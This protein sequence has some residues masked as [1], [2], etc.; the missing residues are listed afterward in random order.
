M[1]SVIEQE[2]KSLGRGLLMVGHG[3]RERC[4]R[5]KKE[6]GGGEKGEEEEG[7]EGR[8]DEGGRQTVISGSVCKYYKVCWFC[9]VQGC[10]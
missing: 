7:G 3:V 5:R 2:E 6:S 8:R 9:R 4:G 10:R 1:G